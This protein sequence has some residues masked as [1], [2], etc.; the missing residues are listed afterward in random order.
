V[1]ERLERSRRPW[2][3]KDARIYL[4][5]G[6]DALLAVV[7]AID[8][9]TQATPRRAQPEAVPRRPLASEA[10]PRRERVS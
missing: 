10:M 2:Q 8:Q 4:Q 7:A 3:Q 9:M 5:Q 6:H 1:T